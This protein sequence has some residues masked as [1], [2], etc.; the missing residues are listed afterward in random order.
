MLH[1]YV[2]TKKTLR[3]ETIKDIYFPVQRI[4]GAGI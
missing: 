3:Y 1:C 4:D 2:T